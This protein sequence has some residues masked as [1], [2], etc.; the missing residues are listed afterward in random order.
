MANELESIGRQV[1]G[2]NGPLN[3]QCSSRAYFRFWPGP[4]TL[5]F[6]LL[7]EKQPFILVRR[8]K[9]KRNSQRQVMADYCLTRRPDSRHS[10][11]RLVPGGATGGLRPEAEVT[12]LRKLSLNVPAHECLPVS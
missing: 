1:S 12:L 6:N 2:C 9:S 11:A 3:V 8:A 7:A 10:A 4:E 5:T